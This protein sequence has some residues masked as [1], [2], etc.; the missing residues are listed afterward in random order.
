MAPA[1][2]PKGRKKVGTVLS[3]DGGLYFGSGA[4]RGCGGSGNHG[5]P[6]P[7]SRGNSRGQRYLVIWMVGGLGFEHGKGGAESKE[8]IP[9]PADITEPLED[10]PF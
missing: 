8:L 3:I 2:V 6:N 9:D 7:S 4:T 10:L 5:S 1:G